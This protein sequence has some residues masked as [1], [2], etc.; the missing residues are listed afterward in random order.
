MN[1]NTLQDELT[2]FS[3]L[4]TEPPVL[5]PQPSGKLTTRFHRNG[6][7]LRLTFEDKGAGKV[8]AKWGRNRAITRPNYKT[9]LASPLFADLARWIDNQ[10]RHLK[11]TRM[12]NMIA[13]S[14]TLASGGDPLGVDAFDAFLDSPREGVDTVRAVLIDGPAGIGKT[15]FIERL[16]FQRATNYRRTARPLILHVQSRGRCVDLSSRSYSR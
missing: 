5:R 3:D 7:L 15:K 2:A 14:G 6:E 11:S 8:A 1:L 12:D 16:A 4:G 13:I 10:Q 9:L